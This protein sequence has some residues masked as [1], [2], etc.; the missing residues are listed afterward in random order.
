MFN[1]FLLL[2]TF[3]HKVLICLYLLSYM[4]AMFIQIR[5]PETEVTLSDWFLGF[6]TS[7]V[8]GTITYFI[9]LNWINVGL[10]MGIT[11]IASLVSYRTFKFIVSKEAQDEFAKGF[12]K[13]LVGVAQKFVNNN[14]PK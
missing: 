14:N 10:R 4:G 11:I 12:W 3:E 9:A 5:D 1:E 7:V 2:L 8:G 6:L 13:G